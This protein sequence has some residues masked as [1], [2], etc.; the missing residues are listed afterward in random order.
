MSCKYCNGDC[1]NQEDYMCDGYSG[2]I[3]GLYS[4][5]ESDE[6]VAK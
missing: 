4:E 2:D 5:G 6:F 1:E 3:D